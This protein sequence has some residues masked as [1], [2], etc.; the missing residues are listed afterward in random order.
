MHLQY[1][2]NISQMYLKFISIVSQIYLKYISNIS[3]IYLD[4]RSTVG[5]RLGSSP[6]SAAW[7]L[8][9]PRIIILQISSWR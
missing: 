3:P 8:S 1:M 9:A 7:A 4:R 5:L 2:S 6:S